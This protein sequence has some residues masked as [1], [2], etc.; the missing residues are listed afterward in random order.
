MFFPALTAI[1]AQSTFL[2]EICIKNPEVKKK[3][4]C[5]I[6]EVV[7]QGRLPHL[8]DR[9][10]MPYTEAC[11]RELMRY[12]TLAPSSLPHRALHDTTFQGYT[13]PKVLL[14]FSLLLKVRD[15]I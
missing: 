9:A 4:Q 11:L 10:N 6:D 8:D 1:G 3:I 15:E 2:F 13:V 7:G 14:S 12:E 5:E